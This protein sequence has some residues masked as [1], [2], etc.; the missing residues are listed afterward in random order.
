MAPSDAR[1]MRTAARG[2]TVVELVVALIITAIVLTAVTTAMSRIGQTRQLARVRL[3]A[4]LRAMEALETIR[5]DLTS[6]VRSDDLFACRVL[7]TDASVSSPLGELDRDDLVIFA[8][9]LH[10]V[11]E[12]VYNGEGE[13]YETQFRV[14]DDR[15]GSVLW[16]RRD[17]VPD[18][19]LDG[20][21]VAEPVVD[22]VL[23]VRFE[24]YDGESWYDEWDSDV[25]GLPLALRAT[26]VATGA[27]PGEDAFDSREQLVTLRTT[28]PLDRVPAPKEDTAAEAKADQAETDAARTDEAAAA[29]ADAAAA[30]ATTGAATGGATAT[31]GRGTGGGAGR[32]GGAAGG[33]GIPV[34]GAASAPGGG[35]GGR[36]GGGGAMGGAR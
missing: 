11:R 10:P 14:M 35:R 16:R 33:G 36:G 22:G 24:A 7:L 31:P 23:A 15:D 5:R 28:I 26:V 25:D 9:R 32:G 8:N 19:T 12:V 29:A 6:V 1:I 17:P 20:G 3:A 30:G 27:A 2:F 34:G 4:H 18:E 21:G 13:E